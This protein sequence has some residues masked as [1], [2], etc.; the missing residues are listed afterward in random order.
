MARPAGPWFGWLSLGLLA[1]AA[2]GADLSGGSSAPP[3]GPKVPVAMAWGPDGAVHVALRDTKQVAVIQPG[4]WAVV[5]SSELSLRPASLAFADD[6]KS[7]LVGGMDGELVVL[8]FEGK[9]TRSLHVGRGATRLLPLSEG[10]VLVA[11][12]WSSAVRVIDWRTGSIVAEHPL[13]FAP[14]SMIRRP[15]GRVIVADA[16]G[17]KVADLE[18]GQVGSERV[19]SI[20]GVN[21]HALAI[22]GDGKELLVAHM[23]QFDTVPISTANIDWGL[24][25]SSRLSAIRLSSF[26]TSPGDGARLPSRRLALDGS[27]HG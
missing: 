19:R 5:S 21:L 11:S 10:R 2:N 26:D 25:I 6:G 23:I 20:D 12:V 17:G 24:V 22:S 4:T 18:P 7:R 9:V 1:A 8:D 16:F 27:S 3:I 14:G 15:D 13:P